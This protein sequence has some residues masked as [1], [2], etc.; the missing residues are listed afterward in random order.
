MMKE[1]TYGVMVWIGVSESANHNILAA[2]IVGMIVD[3]I[4]DNEVNDIASV[5][6]VLE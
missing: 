2:N 3:V 6:R 5:C 1:E 4:S